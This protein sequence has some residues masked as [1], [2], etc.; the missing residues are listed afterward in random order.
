[1]ADS[2]IVTLRLPKALLERADAL[3]PVMRDSDQMMVVG[4]FSR[5]IV[6]RLAVLKG[7]AELEA[8]IE[9]QPVA[10]KPAKRGAR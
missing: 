5:S 7:L 9:N 10:K 1:M 4:R 3:V 2:M 8:Q 6:L